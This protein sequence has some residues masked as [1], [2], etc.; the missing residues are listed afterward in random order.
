MVGI[1]DQLSEPII[2]NSPDFEPDSERQSLMSVSY[3]HLYRDI[4]MFHCLIGCR[5]GDLEKMTR[6]NIVDGAV[7]VSYTHLD[8]YKRQAETQSP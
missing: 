6:A 4:F 1:E 8:V 3:T 2:V 7:A 5:V